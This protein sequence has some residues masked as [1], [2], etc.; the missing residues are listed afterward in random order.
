MHLFN[1]EKILLCYLIQVGDF[2]L[3]TLPWYFQ[4]FQNLVHIFFSAKASNCKFLV[5]NLNRKKKHSQTWQGLTQ[6]HSTI[7]ISPL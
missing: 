4:A 7:C 1:F 6:R 2:G 5:V 3:K